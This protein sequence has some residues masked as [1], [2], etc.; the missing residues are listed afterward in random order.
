MTN[1]TVSHRKPWMVMGMIMATITPLLAAVAWSGSQ[2]FLA[3]NEVLP[4]YPRL[5]QW[6]WAS[7]SQNPAITVL[8]VADF[9]GQPGHELLLSQHSWPTEEDPPGGLVLLAA[10][11]QTTLCFFD[12]KYRVLDT[13]H[14]QADNDPAAEITVVTQRGLM[15]FD[16]HNCQI[17]S[18]VEFPER[19]DDAAL[20]D[21]NNDGITDVVWSVN[22]NIHTAPWNDLSQPMVRLGFGGEQLQVAR[23]NRTDGDDII[24]FN[25]AIT[26]LNGQSLSTINEI[27]TPSSAHFS[28]G[29]VNGDDMA[30]LVYAEPWEAGITAIDV[31]SGD[32]IF[33]AEVDDVTHIQV[34]DTNDDG[35]DEVLVGEAF[36]RQIHA[37][38]GT[39]AV[40]KVI[41]NPSGNTSMITAADI[42]SDGRKDVIWGAGH[43]LQK[44][45]FQTGLIEWQNQNIRFPFLLTP[46][47]ANDPT[48]GAWVVA[49]SHYINHQQSGGAMLLNPNNGSAIGQPFTLPGIELDRL[50]AVA[51]GDIDGDQAIEICLASEEYGA[52]LTCL[53]LDGSLVWELELPLF[54][55]DIIQMEVMDADDNGSQELVAVKNSGQV[56]LLQGSDGAELWQTPDLLERYPGLGFDGLQWI[57]GSLWLSLNQELVQINPANGAVIQSYTDSEFSHLQ[58]VDGQTYGIQ[59][60]VG[61]GLVDLSTLSMTQLLHP[62]TDPV[63]LLRVAD[64]GN[65]AVISRAHNFGLGLPYADPIIIS[66]NGS[67]APW[68]VGQMLLYDIEFHGNDALLFGTYTGVTFQ[69]FKNLVDEIFTDG[70]QSP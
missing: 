27:F 8:E 28:V 17:T 1:N 20:G 61:L 12:F 15:Q 49:Y 70:F 44:A 46:L 34:V 41:E 56:M 13:D 40:V 9:D 65:T 35:A 63:N 69:S 22:N 10:D 11:L 52:Y 2:Y 51:T 50:T 60:G 19:V 58:S 23:L 38:D 21:L 47:S 37:F 67:F 31:A 57:D 43:R 5:A 42:D 6:Q 36:W 25:H 68:E 18:V 16:G 62:F 64:D 24:M 66:L 39:G 53:N 29:D 26:V 45:D 55:G 54:S 30:D 32:Q 14:R 7:T 3:K 59:Q 4:V 48:P 33:T